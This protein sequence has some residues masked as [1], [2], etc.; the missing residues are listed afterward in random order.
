[1]IEYSRLRQDNYSLSYSWES[2]YDTIKNMM[3]IFQKAIKYKRVRIETSLSGVM[4]DFEI[5]TD[6]ERLK[7]IV[8][9]LMS[10]AI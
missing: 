1:M 8:Y 2:I 3:E 5:K 9:N 10:N 6:F 4:G 7:L